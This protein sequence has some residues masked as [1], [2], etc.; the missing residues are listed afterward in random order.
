MIIRGIYTKIHYDVIK[1][2]VRVTENEIQKYPIS[3]MCIKLLMIKVLFNE[4]GLQFTFL[5]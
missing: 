1:K 4:I 3:Y 2:L 5:L